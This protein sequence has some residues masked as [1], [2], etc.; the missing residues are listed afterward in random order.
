MTI[1][2]AIALDF[3]KKY[4]KQIGVVATFLS[5]SAYIYVLDQKLENRDLKIQ[6]LENELT[7]YQLEVFKCRG[8]LDN[9]IEDV[10]NYAEE[11]KEKQERINSLQER[12]DEIM[13]N[14]STEDNDIETE[15]APDNC[16]STALYL[17]EGLK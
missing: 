4:W 6:V 3:V 14:T 16:E 1:S 5:L 12:I 8:Q 15:E 11:S 2:G 13:D 9:L 10:E 17:L 7:H